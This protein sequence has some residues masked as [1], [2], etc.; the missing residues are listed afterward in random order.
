MGP[1]AN[2]IHDRENASGRSERRKATRA[3]RGRLN[4]PGRPAER[5]PPP[6]PRPHE[7]PR[8]R[9]RPPAQAWEREQHPRERPRSARRTD[10]RAG[11][12]RTWAQQVG[13]ESQPSG[14]CR[15][16]PPPRQSSGPTGALRRPE[17][18]SACPRQRRG[19]PTAHEA[20]R[21]PRKP[22]PGSFKLCPDCYQ[23]S[24]SPSGPGAPPRLHANRFPKSLDL[25]TSAA[26]QRGVFLSY[27]G[28]QLGGPGALLPIIQS[29]P[30]TPD[31]TNQSAVPLARRRALRSRSGRLGAAP[32]V[33]C[34]LAQPVCA[35]AG[36]APVRSLSLAP[37]FVASRLRPG[38]HF[39]CKPHALVV[40]EDP[41]SECSLKSVLP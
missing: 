2:P 4:V 9:G 17:N 36:L 23:G 1:N 3:R 29:P 18:L 27:S 24:P 35:G 7:A 38:K 12:G 31:Q 34:L 21:P 37:G 13:G 22:E 39:V 30:R 32:C 19:H 8:P 5:S 41:H 10:R 14:Q 40:Q 33:G 28:V 25:L 16:L 11:E 15:P 20:L 6:A 26:P